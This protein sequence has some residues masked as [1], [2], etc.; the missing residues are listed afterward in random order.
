MTLLDEQRSDPRTIAILDE[1]IA[2][3]EEL[4][5]ALKELKRGDYLLVDLNLSSRT[6][7][8]CSYIVPQVKYLSEVAAMSKYEL[9]RLPD[10][11]RKSY[12]ELRELCVAS[13]FWGPND[14]AYR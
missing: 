4:V 6:Y 13:G 3:L 5:A 14:P 10:F 1:Q 9:M 12:N 7:N 8:A 11:G 2:A